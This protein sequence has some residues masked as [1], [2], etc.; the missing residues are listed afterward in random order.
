AS[1]GRTSLMAVSPGFFRTM[2]VSLTR[3]RFLDD[4]DTGENPLIVLVN[5]AAV[6]T[7]WPADNPL[8]RFGRI[9]GPNGA[10]FQIV[11]VVGDV[12][13]DGLGKPTVPEVYLLARLLNLTPRADFPVR[14]LLPPATLVPEVRRAIQAVDAA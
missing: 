12:K 1:V 6:R 8:Q 14:S 9:S 3:G 11:G 7:Y 10:R 4:H 13:N 2:R 5:E